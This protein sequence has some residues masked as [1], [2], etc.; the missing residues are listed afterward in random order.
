[1]DFMLDYK[2]YGIKMYFYYIGTINYFLVGIKQM[3]SVINIDINMD[4]RYS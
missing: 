1:M 4:I 2:Y 3:K